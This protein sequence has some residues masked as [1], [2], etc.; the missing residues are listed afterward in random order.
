MA[1]R[2]QVTIR[3]WNG[4]V[5][6]SQ[7]IPAPMKPLLLAA[8]L[9]V[10]LGAASAAPRSPASAQPATYGD[11]M[12][13]YEREAARGSARAQFLLGLL[14]ERGAGPRARDP[15]R[16]FAWF[17]KAARQ[18]HAE[19]QYKTGAAYQFGRGVAPDPAQARDWYGRAAAQGIAEAQFNLALMLESGEGGPPD[20]AE[21]ARLYR[22]AAARG[23]A[24]AMLNL[25]LLHHRGTGVEASNVEA[26]TWFRAAEAAGAPGAAD[27]RAG[28]EELLSPEELARARR[29][30]ETR[31]PG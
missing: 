12:R 22:A 18:G 9:V 24:P 1:G 3:T 17:R 16:A 10:G 4:N 26:W 15:E 29:L 13:W 2:A 20:P 27:A 8:A 31:I 19:A 30:A 6:S 25:G 11:A 23:L 5:F 14:Y 21:A 7:P 28:V